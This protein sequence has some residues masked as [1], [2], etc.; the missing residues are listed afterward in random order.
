MTDLKIVFL[1]SPVDSLAHD[2]LTKMGWRGMG[3]YLY[4]ED[5]AELFGPFD[6]QFEALD[7][8]RGE[9]DVGGTPG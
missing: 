3:W 8:G 6:T 2:H 4:D 5:R 1:S 7:A 9:E